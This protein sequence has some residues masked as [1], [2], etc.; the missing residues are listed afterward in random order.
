[1]LLLNLFKRHTAFGAVIHFQLRASQR[2]LLFRS[3][4]AQNRA[5]RL[6]I[7]AYKDLIRVC[8][9]ISYAVAAEFFHIFFPLS[10]V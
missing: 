5:Y 4:S 10:L 2:D 8:K 3:V 7:K 1:M 9:L 6:F